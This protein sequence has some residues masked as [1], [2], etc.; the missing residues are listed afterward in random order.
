MVCIVKRV[1]P[2][3]KEAHIFRERVLRAARE[4]GITVESDIAKRCGMLPQTL[5]N[6]LLKPRI[7]KLMELRKISKGLGKPIEYFFEEGE[8]EQGEVSLLT[9]AMMAIR[10]SYLLFPKDREMI[11]SFF[12]RYAQPFGEKTVK[13]IRLN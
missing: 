9:S 6:Y 13:W 7:P 3:P 5:N 8:E 4:L 2:P 12:N 11:E 1:T 10:A